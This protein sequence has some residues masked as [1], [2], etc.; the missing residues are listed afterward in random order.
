L[1]LAVLLLNQFLFVPLQYETPKIEC[2]VFSKFF[3]T[4]KGIPCVV[5]LDHLL[6]GVMQLQYIRFG[7]HQTIQ[8]EIIFA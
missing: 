4:V 7:C 2:Q 6:V 5:V 8:V 3:L 1:Q